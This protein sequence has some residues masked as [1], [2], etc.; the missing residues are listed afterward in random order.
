MKNKISWTP[1]KRSV[2]LPTDG[3]MNTALGPF[4]LNDENSP[5]NQLSFEVMNTNFR[6][7]KSMIHQLNQTQGIQALTVLSPY[8]IILSVGKLFDKEKVKQLV[9]LSLVGKIIN[10]LKYEDVPH[11]VSNKMTS[12]FGNLAFPNGE[13]FH[14]D[15]DSYDENKDVYEKCAELVGG[16]YYENS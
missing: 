2:E 10:T 14:L 8:I 6:M 12:K 13:V 1:L 4:S 5:I 11:S 16:V 9:E 15:A 7:M 3:L